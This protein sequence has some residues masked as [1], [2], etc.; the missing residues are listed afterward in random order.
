MNYRLT[1]RKG[2]NYIVVDMAKVTSKEM[3]IVNTYVAQGYKVA[4]KKVKNA[5]KKKGTTKEQIKAYA[6]ENKNEELLKMIKEKENFMK[7]LS[8]YNK[9]IAK[10]KKK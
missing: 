3:E 4:E 9:I 5:S 2:E 7:I 6:E 10:N 8:T 1:Q